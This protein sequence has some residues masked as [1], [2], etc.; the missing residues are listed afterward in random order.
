MTA[1]ILSHAGLDPT[2]VVGGRVGKIGSNARVGKSD[3][4][5]VE[6][7][8]SDGSFLKLSPILAVITNIDHEHL[9]YYGNFEAVVDSFVDFANR[10]PFYGADILCLDNEVVQKILPRVSRRTITYGTSAQADLVITGVTPGTERHVFSLEF[11]GRDL[12]RF[13][14]QVP[15]MHN[16]RDAAAAVA[17]AL[18]LEI[19]PETIR[20][21]LASYEGVDRRFQK[22]GEAGGVTLIDDYGH[23][24]TEI[25]ATLETA[26]ACGY[27]RVLVLFQPHRYS[28]TSML[29]DEFGTAFHQ[30]DGVFVV[31]IYAASEEPQP[32]V[33]SEA[34]VAR[35][36]EFGHRSVQYAGTLEQGMEAIAA[37]AGP[38]DL[39]LTLGAGSVARAGDQL[40]RLLEER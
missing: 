22:R 3:F 13:Q 2:V 28:R 36:R 23:H 24:P 14:L 8:E 15:G 4:L 20:D 35:I 1:T 40:L 6:S 29:M 17:V 7:D 25:R 19:A 34:L 30:A 39:I 12:G 26:R 31:D 21:G 18:E 10:V 11:R 32:G 37:T 27:R 9:D 38:G 16:V 33:T 5:V